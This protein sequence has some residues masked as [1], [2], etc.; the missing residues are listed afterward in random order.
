V[1]IFLKQR[2]DVLDG[3]MPA[4]ELIDHALEQCRAALIVALANAALADVLE[5]VRGQGRF[6]VDGRS[7]HGRGRCDPR[8]RRQELVRVPQPAGLLDDPRRFDGDASAR[9]L[10]GGRKIRSSGDAIGLR[11]D[12]G[13]LV[14]AGICPHSLADLLGLLG[15]DS[16][17]EQVPV[18]EVPGRGLDHKA[19]PDRDVAALALIGVAVGDEP[20]YPG[21]IFDTA[22]LAASQVSPYRARLYVSIVSGECVGNGGLHHVLD[23]VEG[24]TTRNDAFIDRIEAAQL[25]D[26]GR[27][28]AVDDPARV[29]ADDL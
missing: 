24:E 9:P 22:A 6:V 1:W 14:G 2:E 21:R 18:M 15:G 26:A 19:G 29:R 13:V 5:Q 20:E 27:T 25:Q 4:L 11:Y 28:G 23:I 12:T 17:R 10:L 7:S 16:A 3:P 8:K